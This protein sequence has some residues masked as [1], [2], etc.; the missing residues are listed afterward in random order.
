MNKK[1]IAMAVAAGMA[2][3]LA[4]TA[5][6]TVYGQ[7]QVEVASIDN[8]GYGDGFAASY[9]GVPTEGDAIV[10]DDNK[11]GRLGIKGSE[12]L[13]G[14]MKALYKFEWQVE[15]TQAQVNDGT[16]ESYVGLKG[17][18]GTF[19]AGS[20]KSPYKYTGGV[21]YDPLV[22]TVLEARSNGGMSGRDADL[23]EGRG[24]FGHHGFLQDTLSYSNKLGSIDFWLTYSPD[25]VGGRKGRDGDLTASAKYKEKNWEAFVAYASND[26]ISTGYQTTTSPDSYDAI[27]VGGQ[28]RSGPHKISAQY[29]QTSMG[30]VFVNGAGAPDLEGD[31]LFLGY[32]F[33]MGKNILIAQYGMADYTLGG[34]AGDTTYMA[35]AVKHKFSKKTSGWIGY[36][37]S[38][39]DLPS[40]IIAVLPSGA[41]TSTLDLTAISAGLRVDF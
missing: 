23:N 33:K 15:T 21:K 24:A 37:D 34:D 5:A 10:V 30:T 4:A 19:T 12:D 38:S 6:P 36:R 40:G 35:L 13:G 20:V 39:Y 2:A 14:G 25:E 41:T 31:Y 3:P 28:W 11:R 1:L 7:L 32:Q 17:N 22:A 9:L 8:G 29:E 26:T 16:R 18:F 27:K